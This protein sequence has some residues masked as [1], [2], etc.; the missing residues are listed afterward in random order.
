MHKSSVLIVLAIICNSFLLQLHAQPFQLKGQVIDESNNQPIEFATV[1]INK[2]TSGT[3]TDIDGRFELTFSEEQPE[4][5]ISFAGYQPITHILDI[6]TLNQPYIFKMAID[7]KVLKEVKVEAKR[8][9]IW[10]IN[11]EVFKREFIGSTMFGIQCEL[12]NFEDLIIIYSPKTN[13]MEVS[14]KDILTINNM[15]LG[16][17][18][19]YLLDHFKYDLNTGYVTFAGYPF[20]EPLP[21]GKM[22]TKKWERNRI[23]AYNGSS[24]HFL[25]A[26]HRMQLE[27]EGFNLLRLVRKPNPERPSEEQILSA[28]KAMRNRTGFSENQIDSISDIIS[29]ARLP[30]IVEYLDTNKVPYDTYL[31]EVNNEVELK[32]NDFFQIV[33]TGEKE[34]LAYV[35]SRNIFKPREPTYQTSVISLTTESDKINSSGSM[36]DP[37]SLIYEGYWAWE[38]LGDMLPLDYAIKE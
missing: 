5:I 3:V 2:T 33:Y 12:V 38:K 21:G 28:R 37:F 19:K 35:R 20:F 22:K 17:R 31:M 23:K 7:T 27:E 16:Y 29:R 30:K 1:Y 10:Y 24:M 8:D 34:E 18:I 36:Y 6:Q 9:S 13:I 11:L 25:R 14:A 4:L 32:F 15:G 26:L